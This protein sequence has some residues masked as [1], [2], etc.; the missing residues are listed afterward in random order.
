[1]RIHIT[2]KEETSYIIEHQEDEFFDLD[3]I[4]DLCETVGE[5]L[6][7]PQCCTDCLEKDDLRKGECPC[8]IVMSSL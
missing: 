5:G 7:K 3:D 2:H 4:K 1:V 6:F 8:R